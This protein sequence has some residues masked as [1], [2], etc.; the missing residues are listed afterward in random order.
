MVDSGSIDPNGVAGYLNNNAS[1]RFVHAETD[2]CAN[3]TFPTS[4]RC[5]GCMAVLHLSQRDHYTTNGE[6][7]I[8]NRFAAS[9]Q[10]FA[11]GQRHLLR[12]W[13]KSLP[14]LCRK[15]G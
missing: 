13:E 10:S 3:S 15:S 7:D 6:V 4:N 12:F 1:G 5:G 14:L 8:L 9:I 2:C 11:R